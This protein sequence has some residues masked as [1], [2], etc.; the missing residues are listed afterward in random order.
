MK[1]F[2][3]IMKATGRFIEKNWNRTL[4][5]Y[6][7]TNGAYIEF[8]SVDSEERV[9]GPRRDILYVNECNNITFDTY[10]QL[11]I[12]TRQTI[13]LD[14][15]PSNQFWVHTELENDPDAEWLTLT[16]KDNEALDDSIIKEIEKAKIKAYRDPD[17]D[18]DDPANIKNAYWDNWW[19]VYGLGRLGVLEGVIFT[20]YSLIDEIPEGA[21]YIGTG[22]DFGY[23]NDPTAAVDVYEWNGKRILDERIYQTK[24]MNA[25]IAKLLEGTGVTYA[26]SAEP[27]SIDEIY[28]YGINIKATVKGPDSINY[29]IQLMQQQDYLVTKRSVNLIKE[30]RNYCWDQ[31][32]N[33]NTVNKPIDCFNHA[34]DAVRYHEMMVLAKA[35]LPDTV[36]DFG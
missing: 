5:T 4:L 34:I 8:F 17:G 35:E 15:N 31:D 27:K 30:L 16:Y 25:A 21:N 6:T 18:I 36:I 24:L 7:F 3:K 26:D 23:T 11:A 1:D 28:T 22:L 14:F 12:R 19:K 9:R 13:W 29:G 33:G 10:H 32:K 2:L 20:N